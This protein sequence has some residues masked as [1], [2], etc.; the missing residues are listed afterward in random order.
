MQNPQ[1]KQKKFAFFLF[2]M[3]SGYILEVSIS[4]SI[5]EKI[6]PRLISEKIYAK[7]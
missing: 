6:H 4:Y 7:P 1:E 5:F 3:F 2:P